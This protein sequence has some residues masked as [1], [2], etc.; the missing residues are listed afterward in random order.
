MDGYR[1]VKEGLRDVV[2]RADVTR[3]IVIGGS[4][5]GTAALLLVCPSLRTKV[6]G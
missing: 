4:A 3:V 2:E 6:L 1:W 5:G